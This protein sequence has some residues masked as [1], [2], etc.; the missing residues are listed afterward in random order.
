MTHLFRIGD[1]EVEPELNLIRSENRSIHIE[2]KVMDLLCFLGE[3]AGDVVSK[4]RILQNIW[5]DSFVT[6]DVL[7]RAIGQ[8]RRAI[9]DD[10]AKPKYLQTIPKRGYL[11]AVEISFPETTSDQDAPSHAGPAPA[12]HSDA[13]KGPANPAANHVTSRKPLRL[14]R[15]NA[16]RTEEKSPYPG[17]AA[18]TEPDSAFF[19]G[20][21]AEI[22]TLWERTDTRRLQAVVGPSGAGKTSFLRAGVIPARPEGWAVV[23]V[24]PRSNPALELAR[25][26]TAELAGDTA[27]LGELLAGVSEMSSSGGSKR[28]V[29]TIVSWRKRHKTVMLVFD[30]FEDIFTLNPPE[31]QVRTAEL[32]ETLVHDADLHVVLAIRDDFLYHC[33]GFPSLTAVFDSITSLSML[34]H[35]SL[36]RAIEEP[37]RRLG[38]EFESDALVEEIVKEVEG[39]RGSLPLLAFAVSKLWAKRDRT[40]KLLTRHAYLEIG[41]VGGA[42][43]GH[44]EATL[45]RIGTEREPMVREIFRNLITSHGTRGVLER[46]ELLSVFP[47]RPTAEEALRLLVNARLLTTYEVEGKLG[48]PHHHCV[49]IIHESL[50]TAW[51]RLVRWQADEQSGAVLR[52]QFRRAAHL[53]EEKGKPSNLL[54]TGP[55]YREFMLWRDRFNGNLTSV[56]EEFSR[57]MTAL[58]G[59]RRRLRQAAIAASFAVLLLILGLI[60]VLVQ[61][62]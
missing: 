21:E 13:P 57:A 34:R 5:P 19:F 3:H 7:F 46:E 35:A 22:A 40:R 53:W 23:Y 20:R 1:W 55:P 25:G 12:S 49:E 51:P 28:L 24:T 39:V 43:A 33:L 15:P 29:Q 42:L 31:V 16:I 6:D 45:A 26:L 38:H 56:E 30:Q 11:L 44:A 62:H 52:D 47:D 60:V 61:Q 48:L 9:G 10:T 2:P 14:L 41:G 17:L 32:I 58:A 54:W 50:L 8:L 4:E 36:R 37:A 18:F 59:R 27:A